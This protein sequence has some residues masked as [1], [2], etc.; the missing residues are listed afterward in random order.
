M[1]YCLLPGFTSDK[2]VSVYT[3]TI[4]SDGGPTSSIETGLTGTVTG[5][6]LTSASSSPPVGTT[7]SKQVI[8]A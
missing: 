7:T 1:I 5:P 4:T 8:E 6:G 2:G 3:D